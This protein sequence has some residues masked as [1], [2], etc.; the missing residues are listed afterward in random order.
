MFLSIV[1]LP[2]EINALF[3]NHLIPPSNYIDQSREV[4]F[5]T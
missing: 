3:E 2:I 4:S 1:L 5:R